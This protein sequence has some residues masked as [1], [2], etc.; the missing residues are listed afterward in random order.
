MSGSRFLGLAATI[1]FVLAPSS[2]STIARADLVSPVLEAATKLALAKLQTPS[3]TALLT[4]FRDGQ[5]RPLLERMRETGLSAPEYLGSLRIYDGSSLPLCGGRSIAAVSTPGIAEVGLCSMFQTVGRT[6][7]GL[8]AVVLIHEMLHALG[9]RENPPTSE[10]IT[11]QV[12][13]RCGR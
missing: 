3:C 11:L 6:T 12:V 5:G 1:I 4:D 8:A 13:R 2:T 9:L 7:P 10:E